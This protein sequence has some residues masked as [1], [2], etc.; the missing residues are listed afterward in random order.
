M[1]NSVDP[2]QMLHSAASDLGVYSDLSVWRFNVNMVCRIMT[3]MKTLILFCAA[4][5]G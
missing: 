5:I 3:E 2:D 4:I 1:A